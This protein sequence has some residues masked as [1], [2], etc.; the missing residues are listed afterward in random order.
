MTPPAATAAAA[1]AHSVER[2]R[3]L[4]YYD[5]I[6]LGLSPAA[7]KAF[8][9]LP[10]GYQLQDEGLRK[11]MAEGEAKGEAKGK[12]EGVLAVLQ[13]RGLWVTTQLRERI[14]ACS[15]MAEL[16][17]WLRIAATAASPLV[18]PRTCSTSWSTMK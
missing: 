18:R 2:E 9:M 7:R 5:L 16:D 4:L 8:D 3:G 12:A 17:E 14:L 13:A 15:E 6:R 1:A 11:A 10:A